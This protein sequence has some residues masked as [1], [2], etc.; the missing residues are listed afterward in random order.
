[1][2]NTCILSISHTVRRL[3]KGEVDAV[4]D[5]TDLWIKKDIERGLKDGS[6]KRISDMISYLKGFNGKIYACVAAIKFHQIKKNDLIDEVD[7][8]IGI[9]TFLDKKEGA[10]MLYI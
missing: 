5:E 9:S 4:G 1:M 3:K 7:G 8:I 2:V 6:L 10:T